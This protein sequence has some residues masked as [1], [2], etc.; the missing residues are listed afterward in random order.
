MVRDPQRIEPQRFRAR[1]EGHN[2]LSGSPRTGVHDV[3]SDLHRYPS[4]NWQAKLADN[5]SLPLE[6]SL[7][8]GG[9]GKVQNRRNLAVGA[10]VGEG[11]ESTKAAV[12]YGSPG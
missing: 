7:F 1:P 3:H 2:R 4:G 8:R 11:P 12:H 5:N 10:P 9:K 6:T